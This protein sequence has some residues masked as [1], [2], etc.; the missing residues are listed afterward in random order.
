MPLNRLVAVLAA[1]IAAAVPAFAL[2][3]NDNPIQDNSFM[4][5]EAYNQEPGVIQHISG[6]SRVVGSGAW[7]YSFTEEWPVLGQT[8]QASVTVSYANVKAGGPTGVGDLALNYRWQAVGSGDTAV[9]LAPRLTLLLPSGDAKRGL[10][11]GGAGLQV[12]LPLSAVIADRLVAHLNLGGTY[13]PSAL[14]SDGGDG[15]LTAFAMGQSL[16]WLA[17]PRFNVL[18][19]VLYT[20]SG[21]AGPR[22]ADRVQTLTVNPGVRAALDFASGLQVVPGVSVPIGVGPSRGERAVLFYL[23]FEHPFQLAGPTVEVSAT[24]TDHERG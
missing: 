15:P 1:A 5:E 12:N 23:S 3:G 19:E 6:F 14:D 24:A 22:G 20:N 17:H 13:V 2:A 7:A 21:I 8:H 4:I 18:A 10:G 9:A 11:A 16:V